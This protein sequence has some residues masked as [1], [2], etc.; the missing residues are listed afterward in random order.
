MR[1]EGRI[2]LFGRQGFHYVYVFD[3]SSRSKSWDPWTSECRQIVSEVVNRPTV[4]RKA[5][6]SPLCF[7]LSSPPR[8]TLATPDSP[9]LQDAKEKYKLT[10]R[11]LLGLQVREAP[12]RLLITLARSDPIGRCRTHF[13]VLFSPLQWNARKGSKAYSKAAV[14]ALSLRSHGG[15]AGHKEYT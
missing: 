5:S 12:V 14:E 3:K 1:R 15:A 9:L 4:T 2:S 7:A 10:D 6:G 8:L 13:F 11:E